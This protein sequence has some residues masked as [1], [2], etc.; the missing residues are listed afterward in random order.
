MR[1]CRGGG[2]IALAQRVAQLVVVLGGLTATPAR[3]RA[4]R[5][6]APAPTLARRA[7]T[8]VSRLSR[9]AR[10]S[11]VRSDV[12]AAAKRAKDAITGTRQNTGSI[13]APSSIWRD[14]R[15]TNASTWRAVRSGSECRW[16]KRTQYLAAGAQA[17]G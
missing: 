6:P 11:W 4:A 8:S 13:D 10:R 2:T 1:W 7:R 12:A 3:A 15:A 14:T 16:S 17:G 9:S 5:P